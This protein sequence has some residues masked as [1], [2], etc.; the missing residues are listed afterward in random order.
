MLAKG[1][2]DRG[3]VSPRGAPFLPSPGNPCGRWAGFGRLRAMHP[4]PHSSPR[5]PWGTLALTG[6]LLLA[7][8][9]GGDAATVEAA[10]PVEPLRREL[11]FGPL[12]ARGP[13]PEAVDPSE[14]VPREDAPRTAEGRAR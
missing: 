12:G 8:D 13:A 10:E 9:L 6:G 1:G 5:L 7:A 4:R 11:E 2:L 3:L 14:A